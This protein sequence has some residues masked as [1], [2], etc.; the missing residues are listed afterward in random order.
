[1]VGMKPICKITTCAFAALVL[2]ASCGQKEV[3][4]ERTHRDTSNDF[5]IEI[6][7]STPEQIAE[8]E[9]PMPPMTRDF[10]G[11][12]AIVFGEGFNDEEYVTQTMNGLTDIFGETAEGPL[13]YPI[14]YP[15]DFQGGQIINISKLITKDKDIKTLIL[16]G[17]PVDTN[18]GLMKIVDS[19]REKVP[20]TIM[21][22]FS[23]DISKDE[24]MLPHEYCCTFVLDY[25]KPVS[26]TSSGYAA[27]ETKVKQYA[28]NF[29]R[30][31]THMEIDFDTKL[32]VDNSLI[33]HVQYIAGE[34]HPVHRYKDPKSFIQGINHFVVE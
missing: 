24:G 23:K 10:R 9:K 2:L 27:Y 3:I 25:A 31:A 6:Q 30:N 20:Y 8:V 32:S 18:L 17:A 28:F 33:N 16:L 22:F 15:Q 13:F 4:V 21:S 12:I 5:I 19:W 14:V 11:Q 29:I 26:A 7:Q 1:M 34:Q